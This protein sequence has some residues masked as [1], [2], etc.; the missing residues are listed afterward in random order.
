MGMGSFIDRVCGLGAD[1]AGVSFGESHVSFLSPGGIPGVLDDPIVVRYAGEEHSVVE[2]SFAV[3]EDAALVGGPVGG[4]DGDRD[5]STRE[6]IE[7]GIAGGGDWHVII[8]LVSRDFHNGGIA[9]MSRG[10]I[11]VFVL[12]ND[13]LFLDVFEGSR[14]LSSTAAKVTVGYIGTV[15]QLLLRISLQS[16][17]LKEGLA[18]DSSDGR[19]C[20]AGSALALVLDASHGLGCH[21]VDITVKDRTFFRA[22]NVPGL[23][24]DEGEVGFGELFLSHG[25][26]L[27]ESHGVGLVVPGVVGLDLGEVLEEDSLPIGILELV[28]KG[29]AVLA[30]PGL[31]G[32]D[33][34]GLLVSQQDGSCADEGDENS[35]LLS[36]HDMIYDSIK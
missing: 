17:T 2:G 13:A 30:L 29:D 35:D 4:V 24:G 21:P 33:L 6:G 9:R 1:A 14:H 22:L 5:G 15:H 10:D 7:K 20:P 16:S 25:R 23:L 12:V 27:V 34:G 18:L 31:K 8:Y 3:A 11:R 36:V 26:E 19:E 32:V 28:R